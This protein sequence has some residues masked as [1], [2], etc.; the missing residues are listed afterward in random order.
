MKPFC[1]LKTQRTIDFQNQLKQF[2]PNY[3]NK[4]IL[5]PE[6]KIPKELAD[7]DPPHI[8]W[9]HTS[10]TIPPHHSRHAYRTP[11]L[12]ITGHPP[13]LNHVDQTIDREN[14]PC[15]LNAKPNYQIFSHASLCPQSSPIG[16][17]HRKPG[18][19]LIRL[20]IR[21]SDPLLASI[22]DARWGCLRVLSHSALVA[23]LPCWFW[24][25]FEDAGIWDLGGLGLLL[26]WVVGLEGRTWMVDLAMREDGGIGVG[27]E[28]EVIVS[29]L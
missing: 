8:P 18:E 7:R 16:A 14:L 12:R 10:I 2:V 13:Q 21:L 6:R 20:W 4:N 9:K 24:C 5:V 23:C 11:H 19:D 15:T 22:V 26:L 25:R 28:S 17:R 3:E 1:E 27:L 29:R